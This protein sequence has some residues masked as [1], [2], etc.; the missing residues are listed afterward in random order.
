M[1]AYDRMPRRV[2]SPGLLGNLRVLR[3]HL[4]HVRR[5]LGEDAD[6]RRI[7]CRARCRL[8]DPE[9]EPPSTP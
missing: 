6:T 2:W 7:S 8:P 3:I 5:K 1:V 9:K 4:K